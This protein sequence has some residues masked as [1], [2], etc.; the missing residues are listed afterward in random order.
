MSCHNKL[1]L[2]CTMN[3]LILPLF[4]YGDVIWGDKSNDTILSELQ[5]LQNKAAKVLLGYS[6]RS[7]STE[8]L[9]SFDLVP[10]GKRV[11]SSLQCN[12]LVPDWGN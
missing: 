1:E 6:L 5:I 4:D 2:H 10:L 7:S 11:F 8:A 3:T 9:R 12:P